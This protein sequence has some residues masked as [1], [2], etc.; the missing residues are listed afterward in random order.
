MNGW[1]RFYQFFLLFDLLFAAYESKIKSWF[2]SLSSKKLQTLFIAIFSYRR[3]FIPYVVGVFYALGLL[4]NKSLCF[5]LGAIFT[6]ESIQ[7]IRYLI[8]LLPSKKITTLPPIAISDDPITLIYWILLSFFSGICLF[9]NLLVVRHIQVGSF[10]VTAGVFTYPFTFLFV[11]I[12]TELFGKEKAKESV[13]CGLI[14]NI[15]G[16]FSLSLIA[17]FLKSEDQFSFWETFGFI[18]ASF[19]ASIIAYIIA[20]HISIHLFS[21]LRK[22][23]KGRYLWLRNNVTTILSQGI[24]TALFGS[25]IW[26]LWQLMPNHNNNTSLTLWAWIKINGNEYLA[27]IILALLDTPLLYGALAFFYWLIDH[28]SKKKK[29]KTI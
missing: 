2:L 27:K 15:Y 7:C 13:F 28:L 1:L 29:N 21:M 26:G 8:C 17:F 14:S 24:D 18:E 16:L 10:A 25:I 20:Q 5:L 9:T 3:F 6:F 4:R 12:I 19:F 11:D 22:A 23:T